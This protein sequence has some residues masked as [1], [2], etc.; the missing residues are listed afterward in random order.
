MHFFLLSSFGG[1]LIVIPI[2]ILG[3]T[4]LSTPAW[5]ILTIPGTT[6]STYGLFE[7]CNE[8]LT[9]ETV[10]SKECTN[11]SEFQRPQGLTIAG[12]VMLGFG[13]IVSILLSMFVKNCWIKLMTQI[14]LITGPTLILVG[15]L[16]YVKRVLEHFTQGLTE[17][18]LGYSFILIFVTGIIGYVS[19]AYFSFTAASAQSKNYTSHS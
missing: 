12:V 3:I 10:T 8:L 2:I 5:I 1:I 17:L 19:A 4:A 16:F 11:L 18:D 13:I 6:K 14:P 9:P 15:T 7:R